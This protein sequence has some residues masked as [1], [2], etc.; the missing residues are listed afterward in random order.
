VRTKQDTDQLSY[1]SE[2]MSNKVVGVVAQFE[3]MYCAPFAVCLVRSFD[4]ER[5]L[6]KVNLPVDRTIIL[7]IYIFT[8]Y[9]TVGAKVRLVS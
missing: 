6:C 8:I 9:E 3:Y 5:T 7:Y 2:V 4:C 1:G